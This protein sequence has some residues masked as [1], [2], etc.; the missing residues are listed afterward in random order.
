VKVNWPSVVVVPE[1]DPVEFTWM[2]DGKLP[3]DK[4]HWYGSVPPI[5]DNPVV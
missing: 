3:D 1:T 5:A 2:P 4:L